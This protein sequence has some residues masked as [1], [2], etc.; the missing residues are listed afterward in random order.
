MNAHA[1]HERPRLAYA[2]EV[3]DGESA[4]YLLRNRLY[5]SVVR[6]FCEPD[7]VSPFGAGGLNR[8]AYC[9]GDPINRVD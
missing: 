6:R 8:Y 2:G 7:H 9:G 5:G 3:C 1:D 4:I